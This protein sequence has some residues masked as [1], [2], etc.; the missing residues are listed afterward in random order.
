VYTKGY[1]Q[2]SIQDILNELCISKGAFYH[3]FGS[4]SA[5]LEAMIEHSLEEVVVFLSP[6]VQDPE[7]PALGKLQLYLDSAA[8]WK[9]TQ[10]DYLLGL[11]SVWY[12]DEN[13]IFRQKMLASSIHRISPMLAE[14]FR[15]GI[16]EG[17]LNTAYPDQ[18]AETVLYLMQG[19]GDKFVEPLLKGNQ[20]SRLK[21]LKTRCRHTDAMEDPGGLDP[22]DQTRNAAIL[23]WRA[24]R[25]SPALIALDQKRKACVTTLTP[26]EKRAGKQ[27]RKERSS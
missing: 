24:K 8:H 9:S 20:L 22:A 4:K 12:A 27:C 17:V 21:A 26:T 6:I 18:T 19:V 7:L 5:L 14:I 3:Y 25:T 16:R 15:Q 13:A 1:A 10:K 2:M 11:L 23:V